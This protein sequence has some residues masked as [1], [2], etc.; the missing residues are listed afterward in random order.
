[1]AR[2]NICI[3]IRFNNETMPLYE[4]LKTRK[5][6]TAFII[7][8]LEKSKD[9]KQWKKAKAIEKKINKIKEALEVLD[10]SASNSALQDTQAPQENTPPSP[11]D[12]QAL[13]AQYSELYGRFAKTKNKKIVFEALSIKNKLESLIGEAETKIYCDAVI[14]KYS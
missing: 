5:N 3:S 7:N 6:T 8:E 1:M 11:A 10:N 4:F 14:K 13:K 9:F 12:I 2:K